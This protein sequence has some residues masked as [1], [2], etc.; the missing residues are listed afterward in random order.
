M[1]Q[2]VK[3]KVSCMIK[4]LFF[5]ETDPAERYFHVFRMCHLPF[6]HLSPFSLEVYDSPR[7]GLLNKR[8]FVLAFVLTLGRTVRKT[9]MLFPAACWNSW[10]MQK[11]NI[12][13]KRKT[14]GGESVEN[15]RTRE[16]HMDI[17]SFWFLL[18]VHT[19]KHLTTSCV[20]S[21]FFFSFNQSSV[22]LRLQKR[23]LALK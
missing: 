12:L 19:N 22:L 20:H 4:S 9:L 23:G 7:V 17:Y 2:N 8:V 5:S 15:A 21:F 18:S 14:E 3:I 13:E 1:T 6:H 11:T 10:S 16:Q